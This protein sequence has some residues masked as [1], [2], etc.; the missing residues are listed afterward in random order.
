MSG[1]GLPGLAVFHKKEPVPTPG[2]PGPP[3]ELTSANE[4]LSVDPTTR[5]IVLGTDGT[6]GTPDQ[7]TGDRLVEVS[8]HQL[9]LIDSTSGGSTQG[10][11][12]QLASD[13]LLMQDPTTSIGLKAV[14]LT[15]GMQFDLFDGVTFQ[16]RFGLTTGNNDFQMQN[17]D[18]VLH[19]AVA[20]LNGEIIIDYINQRV[21]VFPDGSPDN[22]RTMQINGNLSIA[23]DFTLSGLDFP[24][25]L[26]FS[27]SDISTALAIGALPGDMVFLGIDPGSVLPN[28]CYTAWVSAP[29]TVT[30]RFNNY[31]AAPQDPP[32]GD[33]KV[34]V[35]K[36]K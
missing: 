32:A 24:N 26:A 25:T 16:P 3:F 30:V 12:T 6:Y 33:F 19:L 11:F 36:L 10:S 35:V 22:G 23:T 27:S 5:K 7:F 1:L 9:I 31:S 15:S 4:G 18:G 28:S 14:F 29:D 13:R 20:L 17:D 8:N 2:P 34:S 21:Q